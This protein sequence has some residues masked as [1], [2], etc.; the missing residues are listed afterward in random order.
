MITDIFNLTNESCSLCEGLINERDS[1]RRGDQT[2]KKKSIIEKGK[3]RLSTRK[4]GT[5]VKLG[6]RKE[7]HGNLRML[8]ENLEAAEKEQQEMF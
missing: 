6:K 8:S 7:K 3:R 2:L 1:A 4:S 5:A